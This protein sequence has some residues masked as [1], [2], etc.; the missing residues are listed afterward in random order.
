MIPDKSQ[1]ATLPD[2]GQATTLDGLA[3]TLR[4]LKAWAGNPS[5]ETLTGRVNAQRPAAEQVGKTTVVDC[6]RPGRRRVDAELVVQVVEALHADL[7]YVSQ[8]RQALR[9]I[10]GETQAAAQV[11]VQDAL[12]EDLPVFTGRAAELDR[13]RE[14]AKEGP[15]V[16]ISAIG[17]MAGVGKTQL[18]V[19]VGHQLAAEEKFDRVLFVNLR[20]FHPDPSQPPVDPGAV[21]D[22]FLRLL[23]TPGHQVPHQL[24]ARTE[25]FRQKLAGLRSLVVLDNAA[26]EKQVAPL[27]PDVPGC[28]TLV[29]SRRDLRE[30]GPAA[31][32]PVDVF[33]AAEA[34]QYLSA[35]VPQIP[36][37]SDPGAAAR[38]ARRCGHLPLALA[39]VAGH[40]RAKP[41]WT[42]TDHADWLDERHEDRRLDSGVELALDVSYRNLPAGE[43][44]LLRLIAQHPGQ[45][46]DVRAAA[47]LAGVDLPTGEA[48]MAELA[49][50]HLVQ[51][52][53]PG[54]YGLHDLVR[55][56]AVGRSA[57][58]D[59]RIDRRAAVTRLLD[60]YLS[61]AG[62]AMNRFDPAEAA[63]RPAVP[64]PSVP[65]PDLVDPL[66]W[67]ETE[68]PNLLA[69]VTHAVADGRPEY[70][71]R[72][73]SVL[74][75][76]LLGRYHQDAHLVHGLAAQAAFQA[77]D[78]IEYARALANLA[79][80]DVYLGRHEAAVRNLEESLRVLRQTGRPAD[81][82]RTLN[83]LGIAEIRLG[84][85]REAAEHHRESLDL[86]RV[87]GNPVGR[88]RAL[89]NLG[90]LD[91]RLERKDDAAAHYAEALEL[92]LEAGDR[93][94]A[95][96][97][98]SNMGRTEVKRGHLETAERHLLR[99]L[100]LFRE[101]RGS[102]SEAT[103]LDDLGG[104][105]TRRGDFR[106][107]VDYRRQALAIF[108]AS[109]DR[110][111]EACAHNGLGE[112]FQAAGDLERAREEFAEALAIAS[113]DD[114]DDREEQA[115]AHMGLA[116]S[117]PGRAR[118]HYAAARELWTE[119]GSP[120]AELIA[121]LIAER[122]DERT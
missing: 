10:S 38:I 47:A 84:R 1:F 55:A 9:V 7:G 40:M 3:E 116:R 64:D 58:E 62:A 113:E 89:V 108:H 102:N 46:F 112:A 21:L 117:V 25:A 52:T 14:L 61:V 16:V 115:R 79:T 109:G 5:Y 28:V 90:N 97:A 103:V 33:S 29:T 110:D 71:V 118:E 17:G 56:Y 74:Y 96:V 8:W 57:D 2:P 73:A 82:A 42:L 34:L 37:G 76:Y 63:R 50:D 80:A 77:D 15:A 111:S 53:A 32:F 20:G 95:A 99:A 12:P 39:L 30:L 98:L 105:A 83:N 11:R 13:L 107:A 68:R 36:V 92:Y 88:A 100:E 93:S 41:G 22:G 104:L 91:S 45:D 120:R 19:H 54:R 81:E 48:R 49:A 26:D 59:R 51:V 86:Y 114:V 119:L 70:A 121:E 85:Y 60:Y 69:V 35:A 4:L 75:R 87:I 78:Q 18:A 43:R 31:R 67:L 44:Q 65:L 106:G 6:F 122:A 27:L 23:G 94:G 66:S 101:V 24:K 72:M